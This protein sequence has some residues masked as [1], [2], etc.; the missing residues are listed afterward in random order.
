MKRRYGPGCTGQGFTLV[1]LLVVIAI[2]GV[3]VA[4]LFPAVMSAREAARARARARAQCLA[5]ACARVCARVAINNYESAQ[6]FYPPGTIDAKGPIV[7]APVGYHHNW[8]IQILPYLEEQNT[9][10]AIDKTLSV[11]H[12]KNAAAVLAMPHLP[13]PVVTRHVRKCLLCRGA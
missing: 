1:E 7:N 4:L 2:I 12:K 3:L 13:V 9:W 10:N 5:C 6:G 8:A 11:Y